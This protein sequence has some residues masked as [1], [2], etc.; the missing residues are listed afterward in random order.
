MAAEST[1]QTQLQIDNAIDARL[2]EHQYYPDRLVMYLWDWNS[3][4]L[5]GIEQP[6]TFQLQFLRELGEEMRASEFN[7]VDSVR[8]ILR[9]IG[10]GRGIGK[11]ALVSLIV[12]ILLAAF[13]DAK[14]SVMANSGDQLANKT[15]PEIRKWLR[16]SI[17]AH[18]FEANSSIIYRVGARDSWF[19]TPITWNLENPQASAGQQNIGSVNV[20]IFDEASEIPDKIAEVSLSGLTTGLPIGLAFGNPTMA[21]GFF[22]DSLAGKYAFGAWKA[23]SIDS[24]TCRFPNKEEI[25]ED[26]EHYGIDSDYVRVWRLGLPPRGNLAGYFGGALIEA[27]QKARPRGVKTDALVAAVDFAWGGD[28]N[29]KVKFAE[30][31]DAWSIPSV[32]V[33]G[34][35]TAR[36]EKMIQILAEIMTKSFPV[37]SGGTKRVAM[38]FGDGSGICT[39]VFAG[40][41]TLGITNTMAVNWSGVP[42][43]AKVH[44]NIKAQLMS[45]L[46]DL[47]LAGLGVDASDDLAQDMRELL[48]VNF[49]PL[50]FEKKELM[51]K[52]LGRSTDDLDA[53]AML[54]Y[55]PVMLPAT[56]QAMAGWQHRNQKPYRPAS[57]YS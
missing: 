50:Q 16:R 37:T 18:W 28:D 55:M 36:P 31:L 53:L 52:R 48:A 38:L 34:R 35:E 32:T 14:I 3:D 21:T 4:E 12:V 54:N 1:L 57:P 19:V 22:A 25:A 17:V 44:R 41:Y 10:S 39:E 13:P 40:L 47:M 6:D 9:S 7:G 27:A 15:W 42:R 51:K 2:K 46:R 33:P 45:G 11:S 24:R 29:N 49:L 43:D 5:A 56:Q 20:I 8:K 23:K 26:I 30:G